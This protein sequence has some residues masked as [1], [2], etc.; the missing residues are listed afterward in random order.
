MRHID[1]T[2]IIE[3]W[4]QTAQGEGSRPRAAHALQNWGREMLESVEQLLRGSKGAVRAF[5]KSDLRRGTSGP[6]ADRLELLLA[7]RSA[8][9]SVL[10]SLPA[11]EARELSAEFEGAA[12]DIASWHDGMGRTPDR[13][14]MAYG[15]AA[16]ASIQDWTTELFNEA[17]FRIV[18]PIEVRRS[19]R[20]GRP[21]CLMLLKIDN[22]QE[23]AVLRG[24]EGAEAAVQ[25][26]A[27]FLKDGTR[28]TDT[29]CRLTA[30]RLAVLL[31]ETD[32]AAGYG[33]AN[34]VR[35]WLTRNDA[36]RYGE[37]GL[38]VSAGVAGCPEHADEPESLLQKAE[39][40][41]ALAE[42]M[43][44]NVTVVYSQ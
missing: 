5:V 31:P 44:G 33:V 26:I 10:S 25:E 18:L 41:L 9:L 23:L 35:E 28:A 6:A 13:D 15:T 43:G 14:A 17:Y 24:L 1:R 37:A 32:A 19:V 8:V 16:A 20:Y 12:L 39:H 36:A 4:L 11:E 29:K 22:Y 3:T 27:R 2:R 34:R 21:L 7:F 42:Q 38:A 30:E 40:A